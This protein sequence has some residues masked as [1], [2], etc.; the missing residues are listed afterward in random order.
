MRTA[1][2]IG[3]TDNFYALL[4]V[5]IGGALISLYYFTGLFGSD[6][7]AYINGA[8]GF[9]Q[10][11]YYAL[12][13]AARYTISVPLRVMLELSGNEPQ[14]AVFGFVFV[15][16][17]LALVVYFLAARVYNKREALLS[18]ILVVAN[19]VLFFFAGAVLPDNML[20]IMFVVAVLLFA[21][22][23][24][25][26][27]LGVSSGG[28]SLFLASSFAALCYVTKEAALAFFLPVAAYALWTIRGMPLQAAFRHLG[29]GIG[30]VA[31]VL[32]GDLLLSYG[33]FGDPL[34]RFT[35]AKNMNVVQEA[36]K[37]MSY[38]GTMPIER[39]NYAYG[40][41]RALWPVAPIYF[42][43]ILLLIWRHRSI[44]RFI[45]SV[46]GIVSL[47]ALWVLLFLT[48]GSISLR[49]YVGIP[50]QIRYYAPAAVLFCI[51]LARAVSP[52]LGS[53]GILRSMAMAAL[54][55]LVAQQIV[56]PAERAGDIYRARE[57]RAFQAAVSNARERFPG[58][59]VYVDDYFSFR[60]LGYG[61]Q[62]G[63]SPAKGNLRQGSRAIIVYNPSE[64]LKH[65]NSWPLRCASVE[66][67]GVRD[68]T[69]EVGP[70]MART[71]M[72]GVEAELGFFDWSMTETKPRV[73]VL[74][75][76]PDGTCQS[77]R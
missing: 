64:A 30:G 49:E 40:Q 75:L 24:K 69:S 47:S 73:F 52:W 67:A 22:W 20:S 54:V 74:M 31:C 19:P 61:P 3:Q 45:C 15:F 72:D 42:A 23:Y 5:I 18:S 46:D 39:L 48:F 77:D 1:G 26:M 58:V 14:K 36:A 21:Y 71:R 59:P 17:V 56:F 38:Q 13:G 11:P 9:A 4:L 29:W 8:A 51:V 53:S 10:A 65:T 62:H 68:I 55:G 70:R 66:G 50:I 27:R 76:E 2:K 6:D 41:F 44:S 34:I 60:A 63:V 37:F 35:V 28:W 33:V 32:L 7:L 25:C 57:F 16:V 43:S 12:L